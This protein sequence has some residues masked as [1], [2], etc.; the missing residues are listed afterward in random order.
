LDQLTLKDLLPVISTFAGITALL[1]A[2]VKYRL[3]AMKRLDAELRLK[4]VFSWANE[5]IRRLSTLRMYVLKIVNQGHDELS[6][7]IRKDFE[8]IAID[9]SVLIDRGRL[10]FRNPGA[11]EKFDP[12]QL[13]W[14]PVILDSIVRANRIATR[15]ASEPSIPSRDERV[16]LFL[17][18][19]LTARE[20]VHYA[21]REV[22]RQ[23]VVSDDAADVGTR[24]DVNQEL[25]EA[26]VKFGQKRVDGFLQRSKPPAKS[27]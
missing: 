21:Q 25:A 14:R 12:K 10:F 18:T 24:I 3:S 20:F 6:Q 17:L 16:K 4:D 19:D 2:W 5:V 7:A 8:E 11:S 26:D 13:G 27:G 15:I 9:T 22:G 1:G 23:R